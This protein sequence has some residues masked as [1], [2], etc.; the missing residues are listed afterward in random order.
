LVFEVLCLIVS[1]LIVLY[2]VINLD[3]DGN[4]SWFE[5]RGT[6][7]ALGGVAQQ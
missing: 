1:K 7:K 5:K 6:W 3:L 2:V 4:L